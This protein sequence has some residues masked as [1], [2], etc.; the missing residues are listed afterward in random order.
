M[1]ASASRSREAGGRDTYQLDKGGVLRVGLAHYNTA[2]EVDQLLDALAR[3][4]RR[5]SSGMA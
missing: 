5:N 3:M 1:K 4:I 2:E